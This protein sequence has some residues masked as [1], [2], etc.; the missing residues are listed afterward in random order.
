VQ[1]WNE[2]VGKDGDGNDHGTVNGT[3]NGNINGNINGSGGR[4]SMVDGGR[5]G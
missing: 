1:K 2:G 5:Q 4:E 3:V